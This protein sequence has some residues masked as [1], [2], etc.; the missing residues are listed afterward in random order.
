MKTEE[1]RDRV[2]DMAAETANL[3][4]MVLSLVG[5]LDGLKVEA[6]SNLDAELLSNSFCT[7]ST[8]L[9]R[10]SRELD[11]LSMPFEKNNLEVIRKAKGLTLDE[12]SGLCGIPCEQLQSIELG[13]E[14][15]LS[16]QQM[17]KLAEVLHVM[18]SDIFG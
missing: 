15:I 9:L 14:T 7:V 16:S 3:S 6:E 2:S 5:V 4:D 12:L 17:V 11:Y 10:I 18:P 1:L 8:Y 13:E